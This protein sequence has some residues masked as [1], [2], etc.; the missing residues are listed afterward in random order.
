M[1]ET[2]KEDAVSISCKGNFSK[3]GDHRGTRLHD[4]RASFAGAAD[5]SQGQIQESVEEIHS[6]TLMFARIK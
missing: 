5:A 4:D 6:D 1:K 3:E 2:V